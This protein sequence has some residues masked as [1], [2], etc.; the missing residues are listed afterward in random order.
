MSY[1]DRLGAP[2]AV[3]VGEDEI[4]EGKLSVKD[5]VSGEQLKLSVSDAAEMMNAALEKRRACPAIEEK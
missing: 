1:A 2:Y 4:A 5:M 3:F